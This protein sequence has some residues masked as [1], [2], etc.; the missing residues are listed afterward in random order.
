MNCVP[1]YP[2]ADPGHPVPRAPLRFT[3]GALAPRTSHTLVPKR[4]GF[5][6]RSRFFLRAVH[7]RSRCFKP[8]QRPIG[9]AP[10]CV[11]LS[12]PSRAV[13]KRMV[14]ISGTPTLLIEFGAGPGHARSAN[15][16]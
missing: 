11:R 13:G 16:S 1:V 6:H 8:A 9:A 7:R 3:C 15:N 12:M 10:G 2:R 4:A 5:L 14:S